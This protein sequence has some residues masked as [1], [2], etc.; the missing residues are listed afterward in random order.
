MT[1]GDQGLVLTAPM[2]G[3]GRNSL[4]VEGSL[5]RLLLKR[6]AEYRTDQPTAPWRNGGTNA[7]SHRSETWNVS[8]AVLCVST[9]PHVCVCMTVKCFTVIMCLKC[10][11]NTEVLHNDQLYHRIFSGCWTSLC[12]FM[13]WIGNTDTVFSIFFRTENQLKTA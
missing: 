1:Q 5:L 8:A 9:Y 6:A 12:L 11:R 3:V 13:S 2:E 4:L 7:L 10:W